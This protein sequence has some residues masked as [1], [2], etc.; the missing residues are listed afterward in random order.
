VLFIFRPMALL[1]VSAQRRQAETMDNL[2]EIVESRT[3]KLEMANQKLKGI[4]IHDPLTKLRNRLTLEADVE[5]L[6]NTSELHH[7]P[8][9]FCM[10]DI[11]WFKK[12]N[13]T[14]GHPAGD[15]V[16]QE[17]A[18]LLKEATR[19]YDHLYRAGGEEFVLVINRVRYKEALEKLEKLRQTVHEH[20]FNYKDQHIPLT[21]SAGLYHSEQFTLPRVHDVILVADRALYRAKNSGRNCICI[22]QSE[23]INGSTTEKTTPL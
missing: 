3:I 18:R 1:V 14:Y 4:A 2:E 12:V 13:D 8:F 20:R 21:I 5:S 10:I 6:M 11:D 7:V 17:L 23:N 15:Y 16:L 22:A 19:E 9:A